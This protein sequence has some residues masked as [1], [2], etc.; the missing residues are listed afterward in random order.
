MMFPTEQHTKYTN[1]VQSSI[2]FSDST[3]QTA[4]NAMTLSE[5]AACSLTGPHN[6]FGSLVFERQTPVQ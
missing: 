5:Y 4:H 6:L 2:T 3:L 1:Q